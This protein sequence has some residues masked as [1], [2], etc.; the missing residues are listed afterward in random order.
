MSFNASSPL[1][2]QC[3]PLLTDSSVLSSLSL[4]IRFIQIKTKRGNVRFCGSPCSS[5]MG[6][7]GSLMDRPPRP[8]RQREEM[9]TRDHYASRPF[10]S[11][12]LGFLLVSSEGSGLRSRCQTPFK[13]G[14]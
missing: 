1:Q 4:L 14:L 8:G 10:L 2:I 13:R 5:V 11:G 3:C 6:G 9:R 7:G 12:Y